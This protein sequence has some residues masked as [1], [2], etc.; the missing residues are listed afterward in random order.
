MKSIHLDIAAKELALQIQSDEFQEELNFGLVKVVYE[1]AIN[2]VRILC[3]YIETL[4]KFLIRH[5]LVL[6]ECFFHSHLLI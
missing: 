6:I 2:K 5:T 4:Q 3:T 1:W